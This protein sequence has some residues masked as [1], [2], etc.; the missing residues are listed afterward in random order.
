MNLTGMS[1][2]S[3]FIIFCLLLLAHELV[4]FDIK[5]LLFGEKSQDDEP[6]PSVIFG[7]PLS[8]NARSNRA[9]IECKDYICQD[10][11]DC[12]KTPLD[13]PCRLTTDKKCRVGDWYVC[14]NGQES[15]DELV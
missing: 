8:S 6:S 7:T 11:E 12:V 4:A 2:K 1:P 3:F 10:T 14:I 13:C 9:E 5:S 15:C